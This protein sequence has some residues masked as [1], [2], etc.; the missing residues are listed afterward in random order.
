MADTVTIADG[1]TLTLTEQPV[2]V[3][4]RY[5]VTCTCGDTLTSDSPVGAQAAPAIH[6]QD[7]GKALAALAASFGDSDATSPEQDALLL[8][9]ARLLRGGL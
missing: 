3:G 4:P 1:H 8:E 6:R 2:Q 7:V 9:S 5:T